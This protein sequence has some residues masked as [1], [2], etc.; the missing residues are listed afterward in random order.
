MGGPARVLGR[1]SGVLGLAWGVMGGA[2][3][4]LGVAWSVLGGPWE[5]LER[6]SRRLWGSLE[7]L[8]GSSGGHRTS[9]DVPW[10][11]LRVLGGPWGGLPLIDPGGSWGS[12]ERLR[13]LRDGTLTL[14]WA[15]SIVSGRGLI[16]SGRTQMCHRT[17]RDLHWIARRVHGAHRDVQR[18]PM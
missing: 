3:C 13:P 18:L 12:T 14:Q 7:V 8:G 1:S 16:V 9:L 11:S 2:W 6:P 10:E 5:V 15:H 4:V 17:R